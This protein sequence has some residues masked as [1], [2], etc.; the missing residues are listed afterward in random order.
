MQCRGVDHDVIV[1]AVLASALNSVSSS[2]DIAA[3]GEFVI[4]SNM[5]HKNYTVGLPR[6]CEGTK[7]GLHEWQIRRNV[8]FSPRI[9]LWSS[10]YFEEPNAGV[11]WTM[12]SL[13]S[14]NASAEVF[15]VEI[16]EGTQLIRRVLNIKC[17]A[18]KV[19]SIHP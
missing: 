2:Q 5:L 17:S 1:I 11:C 18:L 19:C 7:L 10:A 16:I 15:Q 3:N 12:R 13:P 6:N 14:C 4:A 9:F 8:V